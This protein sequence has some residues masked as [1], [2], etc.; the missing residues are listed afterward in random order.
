MFKE[1]A[2][3][4]FQVE[5]VVPFPIQIVNCY[6]F[7]GKKGWS[8]I[9]CGYNYPA[10]RQFWLDLFQE[11]G[12]DPQQ[13]NSIYLTHAHPD[14]F[15]LG[16]WMQE[17]TRA[18]V[19]MSA[20]EKP[21]YEK[22]WLS[23]EF[24]EVLKDFCLAH[25]MPSALVAKVEDMPLQVRQGITPPPKL[26]LVADNDLVYLGD[27][28]YLAMITPGHSP[29]H[30]CF[31]NQHNGLLFS[32][33]QLLPNI[34]PNISLWPNGE[35]N[36]LKSYY[37]SLHRLAG[38]NITRILP[39]HGPEFTNANQRIIELLDHH[40]TRLALMLAALDGPKNAYEVSRIVFPELE[41]ALDQR[42]ALTETLAHL[43]FLVSQNKV[44]RLNQPVI[45]YEQ[46]S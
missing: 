6:L 35:K 38:L 43:E 19:Y 46:V 29:G 17:L 25:G 1:I 18:N 20:S 12:L 22:N 7:S 40:D 24:I 11:I 14:H 28:S 45:R 13:V 8:I 9:D 21:F 37:N 15:G 32:G 16:G 36:P 4:V 27:Q 30:L 10:G 34:S 3:G 2:P 42:F 39:S 44:R 41:N 31:L 5:V 23:T 26:E 33:D